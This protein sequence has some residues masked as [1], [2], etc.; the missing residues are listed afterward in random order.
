[1]DQYEEEIWLV[2]LHSGATRAMTLDELDAA[3][4]DGTINEDTYV[5]RDGATKWVRLRDELGESEPAAPPPA[6]VYASPTPAPVVYQQYQQYNS[7]RPVVSEID[8]DEL[9]FD[10]PYAKKSGKGK[11]VV[12]GL[13]AAAAVAV[14]VF[15]ATK[16]KGTP[17]VDV[18]A[19]LAN[20]VQAPQ[21]VTPPP[22]VET[23]PVQKPVLNDDQKKALSDKDNQF[24]QKQDAKKKARQNTFVP[25]RGKTQPP[26]FHKGGNAYDPLNAKL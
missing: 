15:G 24:S 25:A 6:P 20:A 23:A 13:V 19:S 8:S 21:V 14:A 22:P 2:Q 17:A 26:P 4:N 1:M 11:F 10:S 9:D 12:M 7:V 3:F 16:L 5:R 18:N